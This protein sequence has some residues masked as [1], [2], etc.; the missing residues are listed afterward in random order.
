[1]S[2]CWHLW[3]TS[4]FIT[5]DSKEKDKMISE[6]SR[7]SSRNK[8]QIFRIRLS[9]PEWEVEIF[10]SMTT[11]CTVSKVWFGCPCWM[12]NGRK[13]QLRS[14]RRCTEVVAQVRRA[15]FVQPYSY[16]QQGWTC[17]AVMTFCWVLELEGGTLAC[18]LLPGAWH[19]QMSWLTTISLTGKRF[20]SA[21]HSQKAS[22][23]HS[24]L[25]HWQIIKQD[26]ISPNQAVIQHQW[27]LSVNVIGAF[28]LQISDL[29]AISIRSRPGRAAQWL[30]QSE[31]WAQDSPPAG[32]C[33]KIDTSG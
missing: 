13:T 23:W 24:C 16:Q 5:G 12:G 2:E 29:I 27:P 3:H 26:F 28:L 1:M 20:C 31:R 19:S 17:S 15:V 33:E 4:Y 11:S 7:G 21:Q 30:P 8:I 9:W 25:R 10:K 14:K 22:D 32:L 18:F 6:Q